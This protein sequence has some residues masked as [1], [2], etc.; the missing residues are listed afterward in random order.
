MSVEKQKQ[1]NFARPKWVR[2]KHED[3][4]VSGVSQFRC[5]VLPQGK[6]AERISYGEDMINENEWTDYDPVDITTHPEDNTAIE[7][8]YADG[9][10]FS[11]YYSRDLGWMSHPGVVPETTYPL[12]KRW[13]YRKDESE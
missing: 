9:R 12:K 5:E 3:N 7:M 13:R 11:G 4:L 1:R 10:T 6:L 8:L 2:K